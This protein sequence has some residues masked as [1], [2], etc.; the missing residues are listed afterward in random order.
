ME[1]LSICA[2]IKCDKGQSE[3]SLVVSCFQ[4]FSTLAATMCCR[5]FFFKEV[6]GWG[7]TLGAKSLNDDVLRT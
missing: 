3:L 1:L 5:C 6:G 2:V 7:G 4:S